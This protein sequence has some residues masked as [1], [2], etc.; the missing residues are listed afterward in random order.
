MSQ[1]P[2]HWRLHPRLSHYAESLEP[3]LA[4]ARERCLQHGDHN[5][6]QALIERLPAITPAMID[7]NSNAIRIGLS[8][9]CT[10]RERAMIESS[11]RGLHPWRKGPFDFFGIYLDT[12]WRS[13]WKWDRLKQAISP[14]DGRTVLDVGCGS[15][16]HCWRMRGAGASHVIG[17]DPVLLFFM[18]FQAAQH[19]IGDEHVSFW[20]LAIDELPASMP[21]FDTVFSMGVLYHRRE[22]LEHLLHLKRLLVPGGELVLETL[23]VEGDADTC[24]I[25]KGRYAKM[26]NVWCLPSVAMAENWLNQC[27]FH[28]I[29]TVDVNTTTTAEQRST[30]WMRFESLPDYLDPENAARTIEGYPAPRRA[31]FTALNGQ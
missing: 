24:L 19:F 18:Q 22:P 6:W 25:P 20:P 27:G 8:T 4:T 31:I 3:I 14:L 7:L 17:I 16:Y 9:D 1:D 15:G 29:R 30:D 21:C 28:H 13:D 5:S 11:L 12:E 26:R 23:V 10:E 2:H